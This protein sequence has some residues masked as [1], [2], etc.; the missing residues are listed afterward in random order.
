MGLSS[1]PGFHSAQGA[2]QG[3]KTGRLPMRPGQSSPERGLSSLIRKT[4][5]S[6]K[7]PEMASNEKNEV[8]F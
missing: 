1:G 8:A 4:V 7:E 3:S 5:S 6:G 2:G